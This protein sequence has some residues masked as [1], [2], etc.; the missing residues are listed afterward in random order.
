MSRENSK[1]F[2]YAFCKSGAL[3][4]MVDE[5]LQDSIRT[6]SDTAGGFAEF[7]DDDLD[8]TILVLEFEREQVLAQESERERAPNTDV[9]LDSRQV[10]MIGMYI[11]LDIYVV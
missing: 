10:C 4:L 9:Q 8:S 7:F 11:K 3:Q 5:P 6:P 2:T 1:I